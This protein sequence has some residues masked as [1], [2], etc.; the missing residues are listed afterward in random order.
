MALRFC[1][2]A[3]RGRAG[4]ATLRSGAF[5][6]FFSCEG[7][8]SVGLWGTSLG[9]DSLRRKVQRPVRG[10]GTSQY[11]VQGRGWEQAGGGGS[12]QSKEAWT[13]GAPISGAQHWEG[14]EGIVRLSLTWR[15]CD[16]AVYEG[17]TRASLRSDL[18]LSPGF[19]SYLLCDLGTVRLTSLSPSFLICKM[20]ASTH[21]PDKMA[22]RLE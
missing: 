4:A 8:G 12:L 16:L 5:S 15:V 18:S 22:L 3:P 20:G 1:A 6:F 21:L 17:R 11:R 9:E 19:A 10:A 14:L 7:G 2:R 13:V